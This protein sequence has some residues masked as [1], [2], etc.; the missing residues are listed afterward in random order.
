[1][2]VALSMMLQNAVR[3]T[4]QGR[5]WG[6]LLEQ[7]TVAS[8]ILLKGYVRQWGLP[9]FSLDFFKLILKTERKDKRER[10]MD[11]LLHLSTHSSIDSCM[12]PERALNLQP[13][14]IRTML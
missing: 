6:I 12:C 1:M 4:E 13:W 9:E 2:C 5:T 11:L 8:K 7:Q 14:C 10:G 3:K